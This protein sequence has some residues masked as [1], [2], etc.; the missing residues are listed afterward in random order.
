MQK[1]FTMIELI[2]TIVIIGVLASVSILKLAASRDDASASIC[3]N[4]VGQILHEVG[5]SYRKNGYL[6]FK[7]MS[8]DEM[9]NVQT[10][11]GSGEDGIIEP[12]TTQVDTTGVTYS[13]DGEAIAKV[14]G[15]SNETVYN[16]VIY[17]Q[18]PT[19]SIIAQ[20]AAIALRKI[21]SYDT[22]GYRAYSF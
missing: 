15:E 9:T 21:Y 11:V 2:F 14:V 5:N 22:G 17:D 19:Q 3:I 8:I 16:I 18:D 1:A 12:G 20:K 7:T 10:E 13:C 4:E 6:K